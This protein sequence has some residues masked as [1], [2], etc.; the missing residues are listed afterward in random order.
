MNGGRSYPDVPH[1]SSQQE[2]A[3]GNRRPSVTIPAAPPD[4]PARTAAASGSPRGGVELLAQ[5]PA[6]LVELVH[7]HVDRDPAAVDPEL[8]RGRL[9]VPLVA[10]HLVDLPEH[11]GGDFLAQRPQR[12][13][14]ARQ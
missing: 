6:N 13:H 4:S 5:E 12:G 7:S 9:L 1:T 10:H 11:A 8:S 14:E 2:S 3:C